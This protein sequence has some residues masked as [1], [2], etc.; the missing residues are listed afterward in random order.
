VKSETT[1][2]NLVV[3]KCYFFSLS[4]AKLENRREEHILPGGF[5]ISGGGEGCKRVNIVHIN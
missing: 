5:D 4:F 2:E 3:S 1:L